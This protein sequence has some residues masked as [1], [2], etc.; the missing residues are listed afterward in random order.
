MVRQDSSMQILLSVLGVISLILITV[1][2]SFAFFTYENE[3]EIENDVNDGKISL[4]YSKN[5]YSDRGLSIT[6]LAAVDD[7]F[8]K[9][10]NSDKYIF[11]FR[12]L[13]NST[14]NNEIPYEIT[15]RKD[16]LSILDEKN[17]KVYLT[18][19]VDGEEKEVGFTTSYGKVRTF[20]ALTQTDV[21]KANEEI[22]KVIYQGVVPADTSDYQKSFRLRIWVSDELGSLLDAGLVMNEVINSYFKVDLNVYTS[23]TMVSK[24]E[25]VSAT[26]LMFSDV[27]PMVVGSV[28]EIKAIFNPVTTTN[29]S[30]VWT[31]SHPEVIS[32][33]ENPDGTIYLIANSIGSSVIRACSSN[34][35]V[36]NVTVTVSSP[37]PIP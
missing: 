5:I 12:I 34:G 19:I 7:S 23:V 6:N 30:L 25:V 15:L 26:E 22:E 2:V 4:I 17:V 29:K 28:Q 13:G 24:G 18:E 21:I 31:S 10:F 9:Q 33:K 36:E 16:Q 3:V 8:G 14:A 20:D 35:V 27:S 11:D 1:G 37:V 32:I